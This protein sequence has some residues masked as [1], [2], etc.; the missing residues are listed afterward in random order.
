MATTIAFA[1]DAAPAAGSP[2]AEVRPAVVDSSYRLAPEDVV[3]I[4]VWKEEG[5][6]KELLVRPDGGV[7]FPLI[8]ELQ[9]AGKTAEEIR[10]E[11][12]ARLGNKINDPVVSVSV[13]KASGNKIY[14]IG[15][16]ARP[17]EYVA[18][19]YLDVLQALAVA[20]GLTPF[21]AE[22]DIRIL[23]K[24]AGRDE[25]FEFEYSDVRRGRKLEQNI[26]LQGGDV[27]VVP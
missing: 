13:L 14:V 7:S 26:M 25:V 18:G 9:A 27:V 21:A 2:A 11:V 20:G 1:Q 4:S 17:G 23:R 5:L 24:R 22:D 12:A 8:G 3:E 10:A 16:V 15:R 19:R 6:R